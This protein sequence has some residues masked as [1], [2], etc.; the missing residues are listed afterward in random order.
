MNKLIKDSFVLSNLNK[1]NLPDL[2]KIRQNLSKEILR[3][4]KRNGLFSQNAG[5]NFAIFTALCQGDR[6][7]FKTKDLAKILKYLT[8]L[9]V[10]EGGPYFTS[11]EEKKIDL[12]VNCQ[13]G[14]FLNS[15]EVNLLKIDELVENAIDSNN[16]DSDFYSNHHIVIYLISNFYNGSKKEKLKKQILKRIKGN[17][18]RLN[19]SLLCLSLFNLGYRD[20]KFKNIC[21]FDENEDS[22]SD[23][24]SSFCFLLK[25]RINKE[26][27]ENIEGERLKREKKQSEKEEKRMM[28]KILIL[29]KKRFSSLPKEMRELSMKQIK[30]TMSGN[31]DKQMPLISYY[32]RKAIGKRGESISDDFIAEAGLINTFFWTAFIIY[33]DFWD[34]DEE[35]NPQILPAANLFAREMNNFF[36]KFF[37]NNKNGFGNFYSSLFDKLDAANNWETIHCRAEIRD[38]KFIIPDNLPDYK[39]YEKKYEPA[40]AHILGPVLIMKKIGFSEDSREMRYLIDYFRNYLIAMQMNDD[41]HDWKEDLNRGHLSTAVVL[42]IKDFLKKYPNKKEIDLG[43]DIE[44]LQE[45]FWFETMPVICERAIKYCEKSRRAMLKMDFIEDYKPLEKFINIPEGAMIEAQEKQSESSEF[46][47]EWSS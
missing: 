28:D 19:L 35:R 21:L 46:I 25:N 29:A 23:F 27:S 24:E 41:A 20:K 42:L 12:G 9:E 47:K 14:C 37:D 30:R 17:I 5:E 32:F 8:S 6:D 4:K 43:D 31:F 10:K 11:L 38:G 2:K 3:N 44:K 18:E 33:D 7:F 34:E 39:N 1:V 36:A 16:Y 26:Y 45:V 13:I 40:S 15:Y 22:K